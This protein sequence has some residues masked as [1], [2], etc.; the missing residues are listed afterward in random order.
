[1]Q[2]IPIVETFISFASKAKSMGFSLSLHSHKAIMKL[3]AAVLL[4]IIL[5][6]V[7]TLFCGFLIF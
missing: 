1:M 2:E 5:F 7:L 4:I 6:N 3:D